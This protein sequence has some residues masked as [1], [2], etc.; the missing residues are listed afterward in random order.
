MESKYYLVKDKVA[1]F[2]DSLLVIDGSDFRNRALKAVK[3]GKK[4]TLFSES[5]FENNQIEEVTF[6]YKVKHIQSRAFANNQIKKLVFTRE[7]IPEI[8]E[9]AFVGNPLSCV[10]VPFVSLAGYQQLFSSLKLEGPV[11]IKSNIEEKFEELEKTDNEDELIV[12]SVHHVYGN[13]SW[14]IEKLEI[15]DFETH[16]KRDQNEN[17]FMSETLDNGLTYHSY[18]DSHGNIIVYR[19]EA[20]WIDCTMEDFLAIFKEKNLV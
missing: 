18:L 10:V 15:V 2:N 19:K 17:N 9:D 3:L 13:Y 4:V 11:T 7:D 14:D 12:V 8:A 16:M 1:Y 20:N 5:V 6:F